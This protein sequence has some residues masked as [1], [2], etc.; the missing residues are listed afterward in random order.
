MKSIIELW[1]P[2][3]DTLFELTNLVSH[4]N[5]VYLQ[6]RHHDEQQGKGAGMFLHNRLLYIGTFTSEA[7]PLRVSFHVG[8]TPARF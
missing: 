2:R 1:V 5:N 8:R 6:L 4:T 3:N 7:T